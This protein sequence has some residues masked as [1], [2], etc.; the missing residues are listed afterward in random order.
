MIV[1]KIIDTF[2]DLAKQ[3]KLIRSFAYDR[4]SKGMGTGEKQYPQFF[5]ED[6]IY[7]NDSTPL[8]G[9]TLCTVNFDITCL[10]QAFSNWDVRQLTEAECQNVCH[11]IGLHIV[12]KLRAL[13]MEFDTRI[14]MEVVKYS[15]MTLRNWGDDKAAGVRC[16]I[17]L[18]LD[19]DIQLC[20]LDEHF[21]SEK[22][23]NLGN[24]LDDID[25][26]NAY[27][28]TTFDYKLPKIKL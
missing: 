4:V 18:A 26:D 24:L 3:H 12:A 22:E 13:N 7:I 6:P 9:Q 10:P 17:Q 20:D 15:F 14:G 19:N 28:C 8:T 21:D 5:L 27:G 11:Q 25:T 2:Y 16:T 23:F 1:R